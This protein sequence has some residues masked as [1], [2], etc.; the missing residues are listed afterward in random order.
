MFHAGLRRVSA[1][2]IQSVV[3]GS[4]NVTISFVYM[5]RRRKT[6]RR[7]VVGV[8]VV[9]ASVVS[10]EFG[11]GELCGVVELLSDLKKK[12]LGKCSR[13]CILVGFV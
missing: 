8:S 5:E 6:R 7:V 4:A 9:I 3:I 12:L 10:T 2:L 1:L 11:Q 13:I